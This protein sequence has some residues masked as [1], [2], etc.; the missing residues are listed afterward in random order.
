MLDQQLGASTAL[1]LKFTEQFDDSGWV[2]EQPAGA[3]AH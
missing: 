2:E 3:E 1:S